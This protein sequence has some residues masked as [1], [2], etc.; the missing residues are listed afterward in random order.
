MWL[1]SKIKGIQHINKKFIVDLTVLQKS[2]TKALNILR[3]SR[4]NSWKNFTDSLIHQSS[5]NEL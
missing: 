3:T 2:K 1:H 4:L 5:S